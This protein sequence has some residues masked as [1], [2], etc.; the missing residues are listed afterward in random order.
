MFLE[1]E[2]CYCSYVLSH[3]FTKKLVSDV[4]KQSIIFCAVDGVEHLKSSANVATL[5]LMHLKPVT[6]DFLRVVRF[7]HL[8]HGFNGSANKKKSS[9]KCD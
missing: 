6:R 4:C 8:L 3:I 9:N 5:E 7:P 2:G 1:G